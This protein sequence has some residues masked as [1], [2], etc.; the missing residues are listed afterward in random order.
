MTSIFQKKWLHSL[1]AELTILVVI[2]ISILSCVVLSPIGTDLLGGFLSSMKGSSI[3]FVGGVM[4][5]NF[6]A[7]KEGSLSTD[8]CLLPQSF[9]GDG[10]TGNIFKFDCYSNGRWWHVR[11]FFGF[12]RTHSCQSGALMCNPIQWQA[13]Y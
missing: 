8:G 10:V 1:T 13:Q 3:T 6:Q 4:R 2:G 11:S 5:D 7:L 12:G 9:V